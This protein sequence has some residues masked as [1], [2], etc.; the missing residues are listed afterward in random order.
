M[1]FSSACGAAAAAGGAGG[2]AAGAAEGGGAAGASLS[3]KLSEKLD[4]FLTPNLFNLHADIY[5]D[6][7]C[8][9][10]HSFYS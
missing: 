4:H 5:R 8:C 6:K 10:V 2:G 3:C 1:D 9:E 7:N